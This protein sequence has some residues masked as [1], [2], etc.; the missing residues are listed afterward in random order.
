MPLHASTTSVLFSKTERLHADMRRAYL[1]EL[2]N[3]A[4]RVEEQQSSFMVVTFP[5]NHTLRGEP[6]IDTAPW[7]MEEFPKHLTTINLLDPLRQAF[8]GNT[9]SAYLLPEDGHPSKLGYE[10][11]AATIARQL[12]AH[13]ELQNHCSDS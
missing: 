10:V 2:N 3:L 13:P 6:Y 4:L 9:D 5:G 12:M 8:K 7:A 1:E 11:A